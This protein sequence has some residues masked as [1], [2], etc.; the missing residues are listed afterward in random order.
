MSARESM[1]LSR[2]SSTG[3]TDIFGDVLFGEIL[4]CT[5]YIFNFAPYHATGGIL[6]YTVSDKVASRRRRTTG[7]KPYLQQVLFALL[8]LT[9]RTIRFVC[10]E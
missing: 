2:R 3:L 5:K 8:A 6:W 7:P 4:I 9:D 10:D 1:P